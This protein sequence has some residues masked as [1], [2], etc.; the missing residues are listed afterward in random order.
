MAKP[1]AP[2]L[3]PAQIDTAHALT[4]K[5]TEETFSELGI[6]FGTFLDAPHLNLEVVS[7]ADAR[8]TMRI[9]ELGYWPLDD[10]WA[11]VVRTSTFIQVFNGSEWEFS[12]I[13]KNVESVIPLIAASRA[14]R[15]KAIPLIPDLIGALKRHQTQMKRANEAASRI[16]QAVQASL[17]TEA[18]QASLNNEDEKSEYVEWS[19]E[20]TAYHGAGH[21]VARLLLGFEANAISIGKPEIGCAGSSEI[22]D[23]T[24]TMARDFIATVAGYAAQCRYRKQQDPTFIAET[25]LPTA[26]KD[27]RTAQAILKPFNLNFNA[28]D[29]IPD[30]DRLVAEHW[31]AIE[32]VAKEALIREQLDGEEILCIVNMTY[33]ASKPEVFERY[34][35]RLKNYRILH[36][37]D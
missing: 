21:A 2:E 37:K 13:P 16:A 7:G 22:L 31:N 11:L 36:G 29:Y 26:G 6:T 23:S 14:L 30:A 34:R 18:V 25:T 28:S 27:F 24:D 15:V 4:I 5:V 33:N 8:R 9:I 32:V 12:G 35:E 20:D 10:L 3:T 1:K 17:N 19:R